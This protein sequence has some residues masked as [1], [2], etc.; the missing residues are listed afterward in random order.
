M[1]ARSTIPGFDLSVDGTKTNTEGIQETGMRGQL[2]FRDQGIA[3]DGTPVVGGVGIL[4]VPQ[5]HFAENIVRGLIMTGGPNSFALSL[6]S[7]AL[8]MSQEDHAWTLAGEIDVAATVPAWPLPTALPTALGGGIMVRRTR[9]AAAA[10]TEVVSCV[11]ILKAPPGRLNRDV[12]YGVAGALE[13]PG[14]VTEPVRTPIGGHFVCSGPK[15]VPGLVARGNHLHQMLK[16]PVWGFGP[17]P[18]A[19]TS[20][21]SLALID[22]CDELAEL[23]AIERPD[24]EQAKRLA[25]LRASEAG[26]VLGISRGDEDFATFRKAMEERFGRRRFDGVLTA[27]ELA[28]REAAAS[29][30]IAEIQDARESSWRAPAPR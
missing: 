5:G 22:E 1:K 6:T 12:M 9:M 17:E 24:P 19:F 14:S 29:T 15:P 21:M 30:I 8:D 7:Y 23:Q 4:E 16:Q 26:W 18:R 25:A 2:Y 10:G 3:N 11:A 20:T 27:S 28:E 13:A